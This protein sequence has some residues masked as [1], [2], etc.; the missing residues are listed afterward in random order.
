M[1]LLP[2]PTKTYE[3]LSR[4]HLLKETRRVEKP[5]QKCGNCSL[6]LWWEKVPIWNLFK[7]GKLWINWSEVVQFSGSCSSQYVKYF[8]L[9][10]QIFNRPDSFSEKL[11]C[12]QYGYVKGGW[13]AI[14]ICLCLICNNLYCC[15]YGSVIGS[16]QAISACLC[17]T[18]CHLL[19]PPLLPPSQ[20]AAIL[21]SRLPCTDP[22]PFIIIHLI[23]HGKIAN[24]SS[25]ERWKKVR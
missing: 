12:C 5:S 15:Q 10:V 14:F 9:G 2:R 7:K 23:N 11:W 18:I 20:P 17:L 25:H 4:K 24:C 19:P 1:N 16:W 6:D 13:Q 21:L 3:H 8:W 22:A